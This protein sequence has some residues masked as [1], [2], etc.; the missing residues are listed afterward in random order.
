MNQISYK[1]IGSKNFMLVPCEEQG[2]N[3]VTQT[4]MLANGELKT[5]LPMLPTSK[6]GAVILQYDITGLT[7]LKDM[8]QYGKLSHYQFAALIKGM[9]M[10]MEEC[11]SYALSSGGVQWSE[12]LIYFNPS[13]SQVNFVYIPTLSQRDAANACKELLRTLIAYGKVEQDSLTAAVTD[14]INLPSFSFQGLKA[15]AVD[16]PAAKSPQTGEPQKILTPSNPIVQPQPTQPQQSP[17]PQPFPESPVRTPVPTPS[18]KAQ[19][20]SPFVP[21]G[22]VAQNLDSKPKAGKNRGKKIVVTGVAV[23]VSLC[24][25]VGACF[26]P[27]VQLPEGGLDIMRILGI[28]ILLG[29]LDFL[30]LRKLWEKKKDSDASQSENMPT[31]G[32]PKKKKAKP[33]NISSSGQPLPFTPPIPRAEEQPEISSHLQPSAAEKIPAYTTA[34]PSIPLQQVSSTQASSSLGT[35]LYEESDETVMADC[36]DTEAAT[37]LYLQTAQGEKIILRKSPFLIGRD[38]TADYVLSEETVGRR[39]A[40][41]VQQDG[42]WVVIDQNSR[43]H[44]FLNDLCLNP[45]TPYPINGGDVL[46]LAK[47]VFKVMA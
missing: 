1:T 27:V 25:W 23:L 12:D 29:A 30:L 41:L 16:L 11:A 8:I 45:Y 37:G 14:L 46:R 32:N 47:T 22:P 10:V 44:T 42:Q 6:N 31:K 20:P 24:L 39:H 18:P 34:A 36:Y 43:N 4:Q 35:V 5:I 15:L 38:K 19:T 2:R 26:T 7:R 21:S 33:A 9:G 3:I 28:G 40:Q 17:Q 13:G